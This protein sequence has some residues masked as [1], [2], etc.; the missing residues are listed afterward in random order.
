MRRLHSPGAC[1]GLQIAVVKER[2]TELQILQWLSRL[3]VLIDRSTQGDIGRG[4]LKTD[5]WHSSSAQPWQEAM[6]R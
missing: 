5:V 1:A 2:L 6:R 3:E 4:V